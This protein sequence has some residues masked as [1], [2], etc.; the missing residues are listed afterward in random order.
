MS[1]TLLGTTARLLPGKHAAQSFLGLIMLFI[2]FPGKRAASKP[3]PERGLTL[4]LRRKTAREEQEECQ[5]S[6]VVAV[7]YQPLE[8][9][10][11]AEEEHQHQVAD[12]RHDQE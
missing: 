7:E 3:L 6:E 12:Q 5:H 1:L 11:E 9:A 4:L 8:E 10:Q 2:F